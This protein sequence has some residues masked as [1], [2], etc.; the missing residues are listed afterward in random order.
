MS[1]KFDET[2][3]V[4]EEGRLQLRAPSGAVLLELKP[5]EIDEAIRL[6]FLD[7]SNP[8]FSLFEYARM[9]QEAPSEVSSSQAHRPE[10]DDTFLSRLGI[11]WD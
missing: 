4:Q 2:S 3:L 11:R 6:G 10:N 9:V 7:P 1:L 8:H 5:C